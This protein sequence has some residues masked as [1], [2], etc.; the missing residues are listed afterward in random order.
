MKIEYLDLKNDFHV[1]R[2]I[3]DEK[4][5]TYQNKDD[6]RL[7]IS[8]I[9]LPS[10]GNKKVFFSF[11]LAK[12][13]KISSD[14]YQKYIENFSTRH[15]FPKP[16]LDLNIIIEKNSQID[17]YLFNT[18]L[19]LFKRLQLNLSPNCNLRCQ[20]CY[21]SSGRRP[22]KAAMPFLLAKKAI[23]YVSQ[24]CQ[25]ELSF[26]FVGEGEPTFEFEL[27][28][29]IVSYA[30]KRVKK[31]KIDPLS[32]N[33]VF[34]EK[35][36]DWLIK[37]V[38][39]LQI[40]CDG[41]AFIQDKYR[42]L[43]GGKG[44]SVFVE[45]T[46][47]YLKKKNK[48]FRV[49]V[50]ITDDT[51]GNEKQI[52]N[53]FFDLGVKNLFFGALENIG[54]GQKMISTPGFQQKEVFNKKKLFQEYLKLSEL[55]DE[56]GMKN[57]NIN[58]I[59]IG[60]QVTCGIYTKSNFVVD[61]YGNVSACDRHNSPY[62][63]QDY[64]FMKDFIFGKYNFK[65]EKFEIDF[66][67]LD[68]L[69]KTIDKEMG[70]NRCLSCSLVSVC[71]TVCLYHIGL[72]HK[73]ILT[74]NSSCSTVDKEYPVLIFKYL[75]DRYLIKKEPYLEFKKGKLFYCLK[76]NRFRLHL[77]KAEDEMKDSPY[78]YIS[79]LEKLNLLAQRMIEYK[80]TKK[81]LTFFLL[82]FC[83]KEEQLNTDFGKKII[84]FFQELQENNVYFRISKPLPKIVLGTDY[85]KVCEKFRLPKQFK[86]CLELYIVKNNQ[87]IFPNGKKAGKKFSQYEN[88]EEISRDF[89]EQLSKNMES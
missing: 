69:K 79:D 36:A 13:F 48:D 1:V 45:R 2:T 63:F 54:A 25:D 8:L 28:K 20:Y 5:I 3:E 39:N 74:K 80:K 67:K 49:R 73:S 60:T 46:I 37:N 86:D 26:I 42:P 9:V 88:R 87:V 31:V 78:I 64:P 68:R 65:K 51:F 41:P 4:V 15:F 81:E 22:E 19:K 24:Y 59:R 85:D 76:Y 58:L 57:Y 40:S 50:T 82:K 10:S 21:A 33:G 17:R 16:L 55:Q 47:K 11:L 44:S 23:D 53:Y 83:F 6:Y 71:G 56:V 35:V 14:D 12:I 72:Q 52:V 62:D 66:E 77:Q 38:D 43:L 84:N 70:V 75:A 18:P 89:Y 34:S 32:T 61:P 27:L 30:K 7:N 29:Q